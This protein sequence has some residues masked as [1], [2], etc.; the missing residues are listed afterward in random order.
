[1]AAQRALSRTRTRLLAVLGSLT[2]GS[3]LWAGAA[4]SYKSNKEDVC[5]CLSRWESGG[6]C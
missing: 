2:L 5:E 1:M 3:A 6:C 4:V